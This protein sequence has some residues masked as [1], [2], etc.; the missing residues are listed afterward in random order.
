MK[1]SPFVLLERQDNRLDS[2]IY[3]RNYNDLHLVVTFW[4]FRVQ[5]PLPFF[6]KAASSFI[7]FSTH[8][9]AQKVTQWLAY[10]QT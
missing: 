8:R 1:K 7:C 4:N 3:F 9:S 5:P 2:P 6:N 10:T